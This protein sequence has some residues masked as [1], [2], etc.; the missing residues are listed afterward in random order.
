MVGGSDAPVKDV[1]ADVDVVEGENLG[2]WIDDETK[3]PLG[4]MLDFTVIGYAFS[5]LRSSSAYHPWL[6]D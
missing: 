4:P 3:K 2:S 6:L 5:V 1:D